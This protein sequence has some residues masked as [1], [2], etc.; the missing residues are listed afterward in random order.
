[1]TFPADSNFTLSGGVNAL[2]FDGTTF[3]VDA[4]NN[5]IGLG[6]ASPSYD[7]D[8]VHNQNAETSI[9]IS[10]TTAGTASVAGLRLIEDTS[11]GGSFFL[12]SSSYTGV[13]GYADVVWI[14]AGTST[15]NGIILSAAKSTADIKFYAGGRAS[16]DLALTLND[17]LSAVFTGTLAVNGVTEQLHLHC[18]QWAVI[19]ITRDRHPCLISPFTERP[20]DSEYRAYRWIIFREQVEIITFT[21][22]LLPRRYLR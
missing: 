6:T 3:S 7:L 2:S 8:I 13:T 5:R 12:T 10:N 15:A 21:R 20:L 11:R 4:T 9:G 14:D 17:D 16:S 18:L 19:M 1:M 22:I